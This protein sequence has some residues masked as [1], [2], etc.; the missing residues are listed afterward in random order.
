[1][2]IYNIAVRIICVRKYLY[3]RLTSDFSQHDLL[4]LIS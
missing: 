3:L 2:L 1:M 4:L